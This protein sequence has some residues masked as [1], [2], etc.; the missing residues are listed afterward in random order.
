MLPRHQQDTEFTEFKFHSGKSLIF[1]LD[2][3]KGHIFRSLVLLIKKIK[4]YLLKAFDLLQ[5][6]VH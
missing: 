1:L 2:F 5:L 6:K 3:L 4:K